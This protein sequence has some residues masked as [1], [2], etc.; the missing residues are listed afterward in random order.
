M[1]I[2]QYIIQIGAQFTTVN[3]QLIVNVSSACFVK[4]S[5]LTQVIKIQSTGIGTVTDD[6]AII[7]NKYLEHI[8]TKINSLSLKQS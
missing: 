8:F 6:G 2:D 3:N 4:V 1:K 5:Y 7:A